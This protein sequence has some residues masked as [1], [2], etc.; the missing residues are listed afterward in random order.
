MKEFR[1]PSDVHPPVGG[2]THQVE[3]RGNERLLII[4]GQI[5]ML[6]DGSVP[7]DPIEQLAIAC[8]NL[9]RNLHA[10]QM[11]VADI[12]KLTFY[13]VDEPA[14]RER[15]TERRQTVGA[16]FAGHL[17]CSTLVYVS[18]LAAPIY[19]VEVEGWASK[20]E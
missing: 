20:A 13:L 5:G 14:T 6:P 12:V 7:E 18:A 17:P 4:A 8:D 3:I 1:N 15:V 9:I 11:D 16:K 19:K 10:A 2:Y